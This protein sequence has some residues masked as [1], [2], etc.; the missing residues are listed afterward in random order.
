MP[1]SINMPLYPYS[2]LSILLPF[3]VKFPKTFLTCSLLSV[4]LRL[5]M[6]RSCYCICSQ[7]HL[8]CQSHNQ[9]CLC[10]TSVEY[11]LKMNLLLEKNKHRQ[12]IKE[13]IMGLKKSLPFSL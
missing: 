8:F 13:G 11:H 9:K 10:G 6:Q 4:V 7:S 1:I 12:Q 3:E 5:C 2:L